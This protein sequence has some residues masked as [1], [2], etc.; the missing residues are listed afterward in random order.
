MAMTKQ[1]RD[2]HAL[3]GAKTRS[4][5]QCR[6]FAGEGTS[7][8]GV[9]KCKYH[10]GSMPN[11]IKHAAKIEAQRRAHE[12]FQEHGI[13]FGQSIDIE[14]TEALLTV[15]QLSCGHL[16]FIRVEIAAVE[17]ARR[18]KETQDFTPAF[19]RDVLM[20][21]YDDERDRVARIAK[22]GLDAGVAERQIRM[23]EKY[24]TQLAQVIQD[25][26]MD[27]ELALTPAQRAALPALLRRHLV[28]A[29][30]TPTPARL[31]LVR[32]D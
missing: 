2:K 23:A 9:G 10:G 15:L 30:T 24:G 28:A 8:V 20:R 17:E 13:K 18:S 6:K 21:M 31:E 5:K 1:Q 32:G 16:E 7:H 14:P 22:M 27:A 11:H 12:F 29:S 25:I 4:G 19:E 3:C 26:F